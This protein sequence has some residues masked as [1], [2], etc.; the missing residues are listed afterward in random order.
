MPAPVALDGPSTPG[1]GACRSEHDCRTA[2]APVPPYV[3]SRRS[4]ACHADRRRAVNIP[5]PGRAA[6]ALGTLGLCDESRSV[7]KETGEGRRE[8]Y[9]TV[10]TVRSVWYREVPLPSPFSRRFR[11]ISLLPSP[12]FQ[13]HL[14]SPFSQNCTGSLL[15]LSTLP[16]A[17][18]VTTEA[19]ACGF[20]AMRATFWLHAP[21]APSQ[22]LPR[23]AG[24]K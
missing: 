19:K 20:S 21:A 7:A 16:A 18:A 22:D 2:A 3:R 9:Q 13:A 5:A 23:T 24:G 6:R 14:P 12:A 4:R 8:M 11:Y 15:C 10:R 17:G 1:A